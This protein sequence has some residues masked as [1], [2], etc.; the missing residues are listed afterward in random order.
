MKLESE[1]YRTVFGGKM[2]NEMEKYWKEIVG[3]RLSVL[4]RNAE[5]GKTG[6][7]SAVNSPIKEGHMWE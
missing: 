4:R 1:G 6:D 7:A 5:A 3:K 2:T